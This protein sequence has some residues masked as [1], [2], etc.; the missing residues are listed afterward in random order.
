M[1]DPLFLFLFCTSFQNK[2]ILIYY[3]VEFLYVYVS[4]HFILSS[5]KHITDKEI[6]T[7]LKWTMGCVWVFESTGIYFKLLFFFLC[8]FVFFFDWCL[9][10]PLCAYDILM[11]DCKLILFMYTPVAS[12]TGKL[13]QRKIY[14]SICALKK[15]F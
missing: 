12:K 15:L 4:F 6:H 5:I 11:Y 13:K 14:K 7:I 8:K 1:I 10:F 9:N 3:L 2:L